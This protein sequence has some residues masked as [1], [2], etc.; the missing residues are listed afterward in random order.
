MSENVE[1]PMFPVK[2]AGFGADVQP[3]DVIHEFSKYNR[4]TGRTEYGQWGVQFKSPN[5]IVIHNDYIAQ[6]YGFG[7]VYENRYEIKFCN[8]I[9]KVKHIYNYFHQPSMWI[10][11]AEE[12]YIVRDIET[13]KKI[14]KRAY[15]KAKEGKSRAFD[16][17]CEELEKLLRG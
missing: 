9:A 12:N 14:I 8:K 2:G 1:A 17:V 11:E 16:V 10:H 5:E 6:F 3:Q 7:T 4:A 15:E 13:L